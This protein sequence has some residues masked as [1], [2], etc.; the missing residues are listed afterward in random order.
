MAGTLRVIRS[1]AGSSFTFTL[2]VDDMM[3]QENTD[4]QEFIAG[5]LATNSEREG[6][7]I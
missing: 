7:A 1:G 6:E 5:S 3:R 4:K 2:K